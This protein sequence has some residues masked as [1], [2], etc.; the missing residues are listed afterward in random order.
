MAIVQTAMFGHLPYTTLRQ[1]I[2]THPTVAEGLTAL[3]RTCRRRL[4]LIRPKN[5]LIDTSMLD[6]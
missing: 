3:W 2:F 1:G 4:T 5:L 6:P